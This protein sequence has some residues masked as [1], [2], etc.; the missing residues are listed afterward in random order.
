MK[1]PYKK[2]IFP[3]LSLVC[4]G[5]LAF[6]LIQMRIWSLGRDHRVSRESALPAQAI[7]ILG[8]KVDSSGNMSPALLGRMEEGLAL[9]RLGKSQTILISGDG[10]NQQRN[11]IAAMKSWLLEQGV[12]EE[13]ILSDHHGLNTY[14][15]LYRAR[16]V[17]QLE[18]LLVVTQDYHLGRALY[19]GRQLGL[20]CQ[21]VGTPNSVFKAQLPQNLLRESL[22]RV[23][24]FFN[25]EVL[26]PDSTPLLVPGA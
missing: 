15:S 20:S 24:A 19:L 16:H 12:P 17:Y 8:A 13:D 11:E 25:A 10:E 3:L 21:G 23:K 26:P 7:L 1:K 4:L 22:A 18:T 9:Y 14:A 5:I 6:I 2:W